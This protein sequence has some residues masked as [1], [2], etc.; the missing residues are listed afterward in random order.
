MIPKFRAWH[1]KNEEM[2][3]VGEIDFNLQSIYYNMGNIPFDEFEIMQATGIEDIDGRDI[4]EGDILTQGN[5]DDYFEVR[6]KN[7]PLVMDSELFDTVSGWHMYPQKQS[8]L[9]IH[10]GERLPIPLNETWLDKMSGD[11]R[12]GLY[13]VGNIYETPQLLEEDG[14]R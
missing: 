12:C 2:F 14:T 10:D 8:P 13:V 1:K 11:D 3:K 7:F 9:A 6:H 4:Y 5:I